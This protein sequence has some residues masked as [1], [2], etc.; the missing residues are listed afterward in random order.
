MYEYN[1][2]ID[3]MNGMETYIF[4]STNKNEYNR[5][6]ESMV[7][8]NIETALSLNDDNT[9]LVGYYNSDDEYISMGVSTNEN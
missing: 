3:T 6:Y 7:H 5:L 9:R 8:G 4:Q 2:E 1:I